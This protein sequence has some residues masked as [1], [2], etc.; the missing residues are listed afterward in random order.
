MI[1]H[2]I[3]QTDESAPQS[4]NLSVLGMRRENVSWIGGPGS[5]PKARR[6]LASAEAEGAGEQGGLFFFF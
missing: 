2:Q 4:M 6:D 5:L 3:K 1:W